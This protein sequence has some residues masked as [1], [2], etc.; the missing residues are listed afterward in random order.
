MGAPRYMTTRQAADY[1]GFKTT[2]AMRKARR[3]GRVRP[4]GRRGGRGTYMW[5]RLDLDAF[6]RGEP[7][8]DREGD[9]G[10]DR[11][12]GGRPG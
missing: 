5:D 9:R 11:V 12:E 7:S 10:G 3:E 4:V 6:L 8:A 2:G 1:C